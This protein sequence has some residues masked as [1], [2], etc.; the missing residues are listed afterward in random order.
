VLAGW[1]D[2]LVVANRALCA[3]GMAFSDAWIGRR[4]DNWQNQYG[5][6]EVEWLLLARR[7][8]ADLAANRDASDPT[9]KRYF[10]RGD[11][12]R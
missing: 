7:L 1:A 8:V 3:A 12:K 11:L 9:L 10:P 6:A 2:D 4:F 5:I